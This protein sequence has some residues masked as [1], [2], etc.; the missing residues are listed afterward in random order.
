MAKTRKPLKIATEYNKDAKNNRYG[1]NQFL[2]DPRQD[3]FFKLYLDKDNPQTFGNCYQSGI[4]AG[5]EPNYAKNIT[6]DLPKW[7]V[8]KMEEIRTDDIINQAETN[9][10]EVLNLNPTITIT[11][12]NGNQQQ[13]IDT[14]LLKIKD[15]T[16]RWSLERL[17][18]DKYSSRTEHISKNLTVIQNIEQN[19][20]DIANG[21]I[22]T[23]KDTTPPPTPGDLKGEE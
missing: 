8:D 9:V 6:Y 21:E 4:M 22:I 20:K 12:K 7:L 3:L 23:D 16:S 17:N 11:D 2:I 13:R 15:N 5:Y 18:K 14:D 1:A 19:I 10:K